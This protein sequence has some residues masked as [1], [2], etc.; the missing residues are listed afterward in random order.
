MIWLVMPA[1]VTVGLMWRLVWREE[2]R[3][4]HFQQVHGVPQI[5]AQKV[6][7]RADRTTLALLGSMAFTP[8]DNGAP[9][10]ADRD[11]LAPAITA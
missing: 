4:C 1:A 10:V 2:A 9:G 6:A 3:W 5:F 8:A 7:A 11:V